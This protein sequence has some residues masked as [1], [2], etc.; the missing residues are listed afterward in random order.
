F[1]IITPRQSQRRHY[2]IRRPALALG[3]GV[4]LAA[5][6]LTQQAASAA[7]TAS[8]AQARAWPRHVYAPYFETWT[9]D[10]IPQIAAQSGVRYFSLG[11]I[12][13]AS[14]GS[15]TL[16][17]DGDSTLPI[18]GPHYQDQFAQLR[19]MGGDVAPTFGGYS[20]DTTNT[21]IADSCTDVGRIAVAYEAL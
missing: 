13:T 10:S 1:L 3:A 21:E 18:P 17:W 7:H 4:L 5:S 11:F 9:T 15:C 6:A 19:L 14:A 20:A 12:Q 8:A 16:T 2:M